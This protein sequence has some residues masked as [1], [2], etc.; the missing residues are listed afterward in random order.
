MESV[1]PLA[2]IILDGWGLGPDPKA[3]AIATAKTPYFDHLRTAH[4][5]ATLHTFGQHVGLP[6]GQMGNSEVGHLNLGA[7]RVVFQELVRIN[8]AIE[9]GSL[10]RNPSLIEAFNRAKIAG[11]PLHLLGLISDGGV[12]SHIDHLKALCTMA[13]AAGV[14]KVLI[15]GFMDGRDTDPK[16]GIGYIRDLE[17]HL[18]ALPGIKVASL[19][20]R[21]YA[22]DRDQRWSRIARA[23]QLL[24]QGIGVG[25]GSA[26]EALADSYNQGVTDEF[27]EPCRI[28]FSDHLTENLIRPEDVALFFNFRT[29]R[30][31][32]LLRALAIEAFPEVQIEPLPLQVY[33]M[34]RYDQRFD[35]VKVLLEKQDLGHTLGEVISKAGL[36]QLRIAETEKYAHV[37]YFFGGGREEP[38]PGEKR[39]MIPS[40]PVA[41]YDLQPEMSAEGVADAA[42]EVIQTEKPHF[43]CLN[44]ANTD[45]VGH[46]GIFQAA[47]QAAETVD[48]CLQRLIPAALN[49]GYDLIILADHG[50]ADVMVNADG[51]PHTSHTMSPVPLIYVSGRKQKV[52]IKSGKL[53][54]IAPT[55]LHIM[56]LD[57][58]PV[59]DGEVLVHP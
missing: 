31:R 12:H 28:G 42:I 13:H 5:H 21:Y 10:A 45:M 54:D 16:G 30:P 56:G 46:T 51:S 32:Q 4:P 29:D 59:M 23:H 11:R 33:S 37:T 14:P 47:I 19:I 3:D 52:T 9:D 25:F 18:Q 22:M 39:I 49:Q 8:L 26:E 36:T 58:P 15:H 20:G 57:I 50:N 38:F 24:T 40:P 17:H 1:Q 43:I 2:L 44:F 27:M 55:I 7:G 53:A 48:S 41:T 35:K 34:T 6:D